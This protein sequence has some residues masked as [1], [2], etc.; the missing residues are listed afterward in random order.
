MF[1]TSVKPQ[2][3]QEPD[4]DLPDVPAD[5]GTPESDSTPGG[6]R[7]GEDAHSTC[8]KTKKPLTSLLAEDTMDFTLSEYP[9]FWF[10]VPHSPEEIRTIEFVLK[11]STNQ[12]IY[13]QLLKLGEKNQELSKSRFQ[14]K[15]STP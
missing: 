14:K 13:R 7:T 8:K 12:T 3:Q 10:F 11:D 4:Y 6:T 2:Y 5:V 15:R 9:T 1:S